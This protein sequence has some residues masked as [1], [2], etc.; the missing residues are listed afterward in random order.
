[1][2]LSRPE[3]QADL[4]ALI[5]RITR[6]PGVVPAADRQAATD[7]RF[8]GTLATYLDKVR[9]AP[10]TVTDDEVAALRRS[11]HSDDELF[12]MTIAAALGAAK[13]RLDGGL[14]AIGAAFEDNEN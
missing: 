14:S 6:G 12:E 8:Q 7:G 2:T 3:L 5:A 9:N 1:M 13:T 11:G 4:V 10:T